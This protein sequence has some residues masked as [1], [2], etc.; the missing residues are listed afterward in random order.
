[1][2]LTERCLFLDIEIEH[3]WIPPR[4]RRSVGARAVYAGPDRAAGR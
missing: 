2:L 1:M 3:S 4:N